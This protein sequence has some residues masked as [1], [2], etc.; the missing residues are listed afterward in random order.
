MADHDK[1]IIILNGISRKKKKFYE[2]ILPGLSNKYSVDVWETQYA[3]HAIRLG[4]EASQ[5]NPK[6]ILAAGGDGTL[7]QALNGIMLGPSPATCGLGVIPLGT[8]N[9]FARMEN[10]RPNPESIIEKIEGRGKLTDIGRVNCTNEKGE[11]ATRYFINVASLGMGP[12]VVRRLFSSDRS[13]GPT[14]TYLKAITQTFFSHQPEEVEV[15]ADQWT[16]RGKLRV[17]AIANGQSFGNAMYI[18]PDAQPDDGLFSTFIAEEIPLLKFL[19]LLQAIKSKKK[20]KD[21]K[22]RYDHATKL[23]LSSPEKCG[24]ETEGELAGMLPATVEIIPNAI[25]FFR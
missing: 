23:S 13:L 7:N 19:W 16:W 9:D 6:A 25:R 24:I 15:K 2:E 10:I 21:G 4:K 1:V 12:A 22:I 8:G 18:A 3:D 5:L 14:L 17:L 20:I 11:P